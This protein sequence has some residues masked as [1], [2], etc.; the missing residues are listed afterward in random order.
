MFL[1]SQG[2]H[3][4]SQNSLFKPWGG[5]DPDASNTSNPSAVLWK[6]RGDISDAASKQVELLVFRWVESG[7]PDR[8]HGPISALHR[9]H[10]VDFSLSD[11]FFHSQI[12]HKLDLQM[13]RT[14]VKMTRVGKGQVPTEICLI[15]TRRR[16]QQNELELR[17]LK[18]RSACRNH[19]NPEPQAV[20]SSQGY[21]KPV[22]SGLCR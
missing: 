8:N 21:R 1:L 6:C 18:L 17:A 12:C 7:A 13:T 20:S 5:A 11:I 4:R 3:D 14:D 10:L 16:K 19:S 9:T 2:S 22:R 15:T